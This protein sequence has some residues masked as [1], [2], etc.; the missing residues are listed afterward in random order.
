MR[1]QPATSIPAGGSKMHSLNIKK[2]NKD[3]KTKD[4]FYLSI[5]LSFYLSIF[6]FSFNCLGFGRTSR[7]YRDVPV[8]FGAPGMGDT[9]PERRWH[10]G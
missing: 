2:G 4:I 10:L 9:K 1:P 5:F 7:R 3:K 8:E 6:L